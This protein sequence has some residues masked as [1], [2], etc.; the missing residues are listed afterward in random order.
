MSELKK[1]SGIEMENQEERKNDPYWD[2]H[3]GMT[4]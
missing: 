4:D 2:Q 1:K 3:D